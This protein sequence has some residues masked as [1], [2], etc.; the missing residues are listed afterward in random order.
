MSTFTCIQCAGSR[1][2][3]PVEHFET[4]H[5]GHLKVISLGDIFN[6]TKLVY[7]DHGKPI[8]RPNEPTEIP[9]EQP[10]FEEPKGKK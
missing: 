8:R 3:D 1:F 10:L 5:P 7:S 4:E 6:Q 2:T 9:G